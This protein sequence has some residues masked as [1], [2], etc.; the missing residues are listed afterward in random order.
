MGHGVVPTS[1]HGWHPYGMAARLS[2]TDQRG[3]VS[4]GM[5]I[6]L[7]SLGVR[8]IPYKK[9]L[10]GDAF[11]GAWRA[12][13][14]RVRFPQVTTDIKHGDADRALIWARAGRNVRFHWLPGRSLEIVGPI[15]DGL[16]DVDD[17]DS[18]S[19]LLDEGISADAWRALARD[20]LNR[21]GFLSEGPR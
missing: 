10:I 13:G 15:R 4:Q 3:T 8:S 1:R 2:P 19:D 7:V 6:A 11:A 20:F 5:A 16:N 17:L 21:T 12:W 9:S 14:H 18:Y